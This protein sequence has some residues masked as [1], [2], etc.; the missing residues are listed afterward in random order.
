MCPFFLREIY[1]DLY[2]YCFFNCS[3]DNILMIRYLFL[4]TSLVFSLSSFAADKITV[5]KYVPLFGDKSFASLNSICEAIR[6]IVQAKVS[7]GVGTLWG[8]A[9]P[10]SFCVFYGYQGFVERF[11]ITTHQ[12]EKEPDICEDKKGDSG[13]RY[14]T[15]D[16]FSGAFG[17]KTQM[18]EPTTNCAINIEYDGF[19]L[20][21]YGNQ[22]LEGSMIYTGGKCDEPL[23]EPEEE[24]EVPTSE[25]CK[26][27]EVN[28]STGCMPSVASE[29]EC[30]ENE[31]FIKLGSSGRGICMPGSGTD[32]GEGDGGE[33]GE[34]GEGGGKGDGEG[35]GQ[36]KCPDGYKLSGNT[37]I[38]E[39]KDGDCPKDAHKSEI[40]GVLICTTKPGGEGK[41]KD[42]N[43][44]SGDCK[45]GFKA[46]GDGL[47]VAMAL[48]QHK[49]NCA[50]FS[51]SK[52]GDFGKDVIDGTDGFNDK[53]LRKDAT[54]VDLG[55]FDT[56]GFG[57]SRSCPADPVIP[58]NYG[59]G[60]SELTIPFS[61]Y[62]SILKL[63]ADAAL[64]I[65]MIGSMIFVFK[66]SA[67]SK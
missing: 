43:K 14:R 8:G 27:L 20:D 34:G 13:K 42:G 22:G 5:Y 36:G 15:K 58:I 39:A 33:G 12:I 37:C 49:T 55:S 59:L 67:G 47:L 17:G 41:D 25:S 46:E 3:M 32:P 61:R 53:N 31:N 65:T 63:F 23:P 28:T 4:F 48:E 51:E 57:W 35:E 2:F 60:S 10:P 29:S 45:A 64:A 16:P 1:G 11:P 21:P 26:P 24:Q 54:D 19:W 62:C 56:K 9:S 40:N 66:P 6:P 18:C 44:F 50:L 38:G 30:Q 52:K 7:A